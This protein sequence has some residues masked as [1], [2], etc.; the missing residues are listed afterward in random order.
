[1]QVPA[2]IQYESDRESTQLP[3]HASKHPFA[4]HRLNVATFNRR[5]ATRRFNTP[6]FV[7]VAFFDGLERLQQEQSKLRS[8][9]G[10]QL[11]RPLLKL[12]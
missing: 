9:V 12:C 3:T 1:M 2:R 5:G 7:D 11:G 4:R 8:I 6:R 10:R